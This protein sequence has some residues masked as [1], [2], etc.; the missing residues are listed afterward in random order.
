MEAVSFDSAAGD[1]SLETQGAVL[2]TDR[3]GHRYLKEH[4]VDYVVHLV[5]LEHG[6]PNR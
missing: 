2:I 3:L 4:H 1:T 6:R 5:I